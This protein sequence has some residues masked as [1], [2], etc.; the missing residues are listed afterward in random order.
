MKEANPNCRYCKGSG[1]IK[2]YTEMGSRDVEVVPC[3]CT[4]EDDGECDF[5]RENDDDEELPE[6]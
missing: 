5:Q 3:D 2:E 6:D 1:T 4:Y